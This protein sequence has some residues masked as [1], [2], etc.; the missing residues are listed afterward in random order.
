MI[1]NEEKTLF[2]KIYEIKVGNP[3]LTIFILKL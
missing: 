2:N 3:T 1:T